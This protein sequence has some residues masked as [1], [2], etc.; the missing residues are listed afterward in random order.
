MEIYGTKQIILFVLINWRQK[1]MRRGEPLKKHI[2][3]T[4]K[5]NKKKNLTKDYVN[6]K[7][8]A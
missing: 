4:N 6:Y 3:K 8:W 7:K 2:R 1:D 5:Y